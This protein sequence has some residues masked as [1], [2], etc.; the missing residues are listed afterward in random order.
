[1]DGFWRRRQDSPSMISLRAVE[2]SRSTADWAS[3]G[4][5]GA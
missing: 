2:A 5:A 3:S 1:M 4:P